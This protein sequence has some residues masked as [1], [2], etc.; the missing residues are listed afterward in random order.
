[1]TAAAAPLRNSRTGRAAAGGPADVPG[2]PSVRSTP[3]I[4]VC[5][6]NAHPGGVRELAG[7]AL[8]QPVAPLGVARRPNGPR[9]SRRPGWPA[10]P[11]RRAS[12]R[13]HRRSA[14]T[15]RPAGCPRVIVPVLSSSSVFTSP[16]AST[17]RP[18]IAST[19]RCTS[20]SMPAIPIADSSAPIVVG[21][22]QTSSETRTIP[23]TPLS[24]SAALFGHARA[25][26]PSRRSPAAAGS[27]TAS[28]KMIVSEASRMFSA[29]SFGVFCRF[30]PST[31]AI[32]RSMK[33]SP[34]FWVISHDDP[35]G[36][37]PGAAGDRGAVAADL[38]DDRRRLAGDGRLVDAGDAVDDVAVAGDDVARPRTTTMSPCRNCGAGTDSSGGLHR[39]AGLPAGQAPRDRV[40]LGPA[41]RVRLRLAAALGD[42]LGQ[43]GEH[44]RQPQ[45][46]H[47]QP[48][49]HAGVGDREHRGEHG[50]D[51]DDEHDRV[52]PQR[53]RVE[54][55]Q[56][57]RQRRPQHLRV[58]QPALTRRVPADGPGRRAPVRGW[59][60]AMVVI[61]ADPSASGPSASAGK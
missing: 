47:D 3:H 38:A 37:H 52:A 56:R 23:V 9:A 1:M 31:R 27:P 43:V 33:L 42:R 61:S 12:A 16:A 7:G 54:L 14:G 30:A 17:A 4:R 20:R 49:E 28:R 13:R 46:D 6:V 11:R 10:A 60:A 21:I 8:A 39:I 18:L 19:L 41:Q 45:P 2:A 57:V 25:A 48:G 55:A 26:A 24:V 22:R 34:G 44:H 35:V 50:A 36:E 15:R 58:E 53:A 40:G 5:A 29:I 59:S 51:L 32:I